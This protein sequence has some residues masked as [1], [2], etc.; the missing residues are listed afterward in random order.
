M[1]WPLKKISEQK[2]NI[3]DETFSSCKYI[4]KYDHIH[5]GKQLNHFMMHSS[6]TIQCMNK[7]CVTF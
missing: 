2:Q 4:E 6:E 7:S 1:M 5:K 3:H